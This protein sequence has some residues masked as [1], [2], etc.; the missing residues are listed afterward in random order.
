MTNTNG[1]EI[2]YSSRI[3][4]PVSSFFLP[5]EEGEASQNFLGRRKAVDGPMGVFF[6]ELVRDGIRNIHTCVWEAG[7]AS[8]GLLTS[9]NILPENCFWPHPAVA[10]KHQGVCRT[11]D[12]QDKVDRRPA[13]QAPARGAVGV[14]VCRVLGRKEGGRINLSNT[15]LGLAQSG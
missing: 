6:A 2:N 9:T 3:R 7:N 14:H 1:L 15:I 12:T 8:P 4:R 5:K 13:C 10:Q 11:D